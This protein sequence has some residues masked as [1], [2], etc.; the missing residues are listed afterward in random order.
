[1]KILDG[2]STPSPT[3]SVVSGPSNSV[4]CPGA[5]ANSEYKEYVAGLIVG[6]GA[7]VVEPGRDLKETGILKGVG[8][9]G[10]GDRGRTDRGSLTTHEQVF[11][12]T[13]GEDE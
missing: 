7:R 9:P 6:R 11:S 5:C 2:L 1:M 13:T 3:S 8:P 12:S 4:P 10:L